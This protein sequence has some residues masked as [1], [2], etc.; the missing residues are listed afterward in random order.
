MRRALADGED[1]AA[2]QFGEALLVPDGHLD[3][4]ARDDV[5]S[6]LGERGRGQRV[7][8]G[9]DQVAGEVDCCGDRGDVLHR[10]LLLG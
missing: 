6:G 2:L 4:Q 1:A 5:A 8:R 9:V 7:G 10:L 3:R